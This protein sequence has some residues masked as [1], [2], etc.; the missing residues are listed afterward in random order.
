MSYV[1]VNIPA[2]LTDEIDKI[3]D[4]KSLGYTSRAEFVKDA[5]RQLLNKIKNN[6]GK[7]K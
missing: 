2:S 1:G 7:K 5:T 4:S 3:I 6:G